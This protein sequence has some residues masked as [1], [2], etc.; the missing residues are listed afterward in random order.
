MEN[1]CEGCNC[2]DGCLVYPTLNNCFY[3]DIEGC[4][5]KTCIIKMMCIRDCADLTAHTKKRNNAM[6]TIT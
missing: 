1:E 4:P 2:C 5:C 6:K 3:N